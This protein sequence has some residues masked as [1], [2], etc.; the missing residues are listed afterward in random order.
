MFSQSRKTLIVC[1]SAI[2]LVGSFQVA[3]ADIEANKAAARRSIEEVWSQGNLDIIEEIFAI[4][5]ED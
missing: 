1:I 3:S 4:P 5:T 2:L